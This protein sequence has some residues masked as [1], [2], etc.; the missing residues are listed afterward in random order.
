MLSDANIPIME[1][2]AQDPDR[3]V[4]FVDLVPGRLYNITLWTVSG[5]VT[6]KPLERQDRLHPE[7]VSNLN[8]TRITDNE[9]TLEWQPPRGDWHHFDVVYQD[10]K[11][12]LIQKTSQTNS[13]TIGRLRPFKNYTFSVS[14]VSGTPSTNQK[15]SSSI[16]DS[17]KTKESVPGS[18]TAFE[19]SGVQPSR[20]TFKWDLPSIEA[21]GVITGF[22]IEYYHQDELDSAPHQRS[23]FSPNDRQGTFIENLIMYVLMYMYLCSTY[24]ASSCKL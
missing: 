19:P 15:K 1:K 7:T 17:F 6:S 24:L 9:I 4:T 11:N 3:K 22:V 18:L 14:T 2:A 20:I 10:P 23:E 12:R 5:G 16:A 13:I 21:N 8:A